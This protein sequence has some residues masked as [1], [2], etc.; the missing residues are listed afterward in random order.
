MATRYVF[1]YK[2]DLADF[3]RHLWAV[4]E[5]GG[6]SG[7]FTGKVDDEKFIHMEHDWFELYKIQEITED[8]AYGVVFSQMTPYPERVSGAEPWKRSVYEGECKHNFDEEGN[9]VDSF[10]TSANMTLDFTDP[11]NPKGYL[12]KIK[13]TLSAEDIRR[14]VEAAKLF[15]TAFLKERME[16]EFLLLDQQKTPLEK[17]TWAEQSRQA[18][19][20][21]SSGNEADAP[22]IVQLA[23]ARGRTFTQQLEKVEEKVAEWNSKIATVLGPYQRRVDYIKSATTYEEIYNYENAGA[24]EFNGAAVVATPPS[25]Y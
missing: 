7:W 5:I 14:G 6:Y 19:L 17:A 20:Y 3:R 21:R 8:V 15:K 13:H 18:T 9:Y 4:E 2:P 11:E 24:S 12:P 1:Y 10:W 16:K 22:L 25:D 23:I